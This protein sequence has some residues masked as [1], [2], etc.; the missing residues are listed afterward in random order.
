MTK[1]IRSTSSCWEGLGLIEGGL[2]DPWKMGSAPDRQAG[3]PVASRRAFSARSPVDGS[4]I[5]DRSLLPFKGGP[6]RLRGICIFLR[7]S[8][9]LMIVL[10]SAV[11]VSFFGANLLIQPRM[12]VYTRNN[13]TLYLVPSLIP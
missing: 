3:R 2:G 1:T 11:Q 12:I 9:L 5:V 4:A 8:P 10:P 13:P 7:E 6:R